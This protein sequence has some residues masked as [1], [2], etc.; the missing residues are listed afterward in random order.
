MYSVVA[1][2]E[3]STGL[4]ETLVNAPSSVVMPEAVASSITPF[5]AFFVWNEKSSVVCTYDGFL[6]SE[7]VRDSSVETAISSPKVTVNT[8]LF[9]DTVAPALPKTSIESTPLKS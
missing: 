7:I 3:V 9:T 4:P 8:L 2:A 5:V 6:I 1:P